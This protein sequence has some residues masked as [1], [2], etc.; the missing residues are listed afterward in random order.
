LTRDPPE[1]ARREGKVKEAQGGERLPFPSA[2][3]IGEDGSEHGVF[4]RQP[5]EAYVAAA[6]AVGAKRLDADP[7]SPLEAIRR[8]GRMATVEVESVCDLATPRAAAHLWG[9]ASDWKVKPVRVLTGWMW[10][11]A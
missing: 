8:F 3:F 1:A 9:L 7:P 6:E 10:E 4:G 2:V 11:G 5:Y